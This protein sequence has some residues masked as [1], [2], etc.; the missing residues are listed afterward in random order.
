[1]KQLLIF[2]AIF[3]IA[4]SAQPPAGSV[5]DAVASRGSIPGVSAELKL[6]KVFAKDL[7]AMLAMSDLPSPGGKT[8]SAG[9]G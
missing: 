8:A 5:Q 3:S 4:S 9:R 7:G 6:P 2:A 1:M